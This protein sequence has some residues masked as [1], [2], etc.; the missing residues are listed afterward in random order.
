MAA[1]SDGDLYVAAALRE[2][3]QL[4]VERGV[5][6]VARPDGFLGDPAVRIGIPEQLARIEVALRTAG[7]DGAVD[8][9]I[10][11]LN[12]AAERAAPAG[13]APLLVTAAELTFIDG[14][15]M[16]TGGDT[17]A[18]DALRRA[19]LGRL[20]TALDP[21]VAEATDRVG[22]ARRYKRF[23]KNAHFGGLVQHPP[24]DLDA[25]VVSRVV[26]GLFH[27]IGQEER[28]I[29][30]DPAARPSARLQEVFGTQR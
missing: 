13:R 19:G 30:S 23:M 22:T 16:L 12:R 20:V 10:V 9:F 8:K 26:E 17:A 1:A 5:A 3:L 6:V 14:Y 4:A 28:R 25:Y 27:A 24:V 18:T 7:Q 11:S 29:R 21:A 2:A 15:R